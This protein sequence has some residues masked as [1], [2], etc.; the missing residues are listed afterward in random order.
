MVDHRA[1]ARTQAYAITRAAAARRM[2]VGWLTGTRL[3]ADEAGPSFRGLDGVYDDAPDDEL[4]FLTTVTGRAGPSETVVRLFI[5]RDTVTP[6]Q[7]LTAELSVWRGSGVER[8]EI[9]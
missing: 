9:E 8:A 6:E 1:S 2:L 5:D 4:T 3:L 7:G